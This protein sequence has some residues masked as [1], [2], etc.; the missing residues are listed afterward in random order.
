[1]TRELVRAHPH[2]VAQSNRVDPDPWLFED[3]RQPV[4]DGAIQGWDPTVDLH[5]TR[6]VRLDPTSIR[7]DCELSDAAPL[8]LAVVWTC[9]TTSLRGGQS[10]P[11]ASDSN[12]VETPL[13]LVGAQLFEKVVVQTQVI[14]AGVHVSASPLAPRLPGSVLWTDERE[15]NL[16][17][18]AARFPMEWLDFNASGWLSPMAAWYLDWSPDEPEMPAMGAIRLYLNS[19]HEPLHEALVAADPT[20]EQLLL[21][22]AVEFDVARTL[23]SRALASDDF[24]RDEENTEDG[25]VGAA[26]ATLISALFPSDTPEGLRAKWRTDPRRIE[27]MLQAAMGLFRN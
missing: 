8:S 22:Q 10:F 27:V 24:W 20:P 26:I 7:R 11:L 16:G 1:M 14:L 4:P 25:T 23:V 5:I 3:S 2:R 18:R 15:F 21:R 9:S 13:T 6:I 19:A 12:Q 17:G